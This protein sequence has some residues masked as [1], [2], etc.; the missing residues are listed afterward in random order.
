MTVSY[1]KKA[2]KQLRAKPVKLQKFIKHSAP[3]ERACGKNNFRCKVTGR[4]GGHIKKYG[5]GICR[6]TF[7][8]IATK[9]G[10]KKY[11]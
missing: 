9:I 10:F 2:F 1:Y 5:L 7:R 6:Q 4:T 11:N 3:K 8:D